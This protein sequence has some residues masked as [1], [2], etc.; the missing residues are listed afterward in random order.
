MT[1]AGEKKCR[2][3]TLSGREVTEAISFTSSAEVFDA[4][5]APGLQISSS[6]RKID[7][8]SSMSSNTASMIMSHSAKLPMSVE[9]EMRPM[10]V[11][12]SSE[13]IR[14]FDAVRS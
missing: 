6:W 4:S 14:P 9:P 3:M 5:K 7:F 1:L 12:T 13:L 2:P 8:F 10:R 11:S